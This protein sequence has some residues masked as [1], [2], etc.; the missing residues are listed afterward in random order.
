MKKKTV[1][2]VPRVNALVILSALCMVCSAVV[3]VVWAN[4]ETAISRPMFWLQIL[5]PIAANLLFALTALLDC[6]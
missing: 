6:R 5:L 4:G 2:W 3:R 1:Y